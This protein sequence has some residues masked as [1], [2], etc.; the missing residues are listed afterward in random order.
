MQ[1]IIG[2][3]IGMT[4]LFNA[5]TGKAVPVPV[6]HVEPNVVH[7]VKTTENDGYSAVQIG[8]D[9]ISEKKVNKPMVGHCKKCNSTPTRVTKEFKLDSATEVLTQ[10]QRVGL[11]ILD[12][13]KFVDIIGVSKGRG[14]TGTIKKFNFRRGRETHGNTNHR[15][16]GSSG[17]NTYPGRVFP[18]LKMSGQW[19]AG[20]VTVKNLQVINI[21]KESSI[22]YVKG[23]V[24][25]ATKGVVYIM[26]RR[27]RTAK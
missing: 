26:K 8:Y 23:A 27:S 11:E 10:G 20:Q 1:G 25:G 9:L 3:K 5:E 19:G 13:I 21:D 12:D 22:L 4:K 15:E 7:Q 24:P 18:G 17:A 2:R 6:I 16:R 14:F